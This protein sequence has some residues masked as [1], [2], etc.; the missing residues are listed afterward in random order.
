MITENEMYWL[1]RA[2]SIKDT[3]FTIYLPLFIVS[4]INL[5]ICLILQ[6]YL[7][8]FPRQGPE[9]FSVAARNFTK[10]FFIYGLTLSIVLYAGNSLIMTTAEHAAVKVI[11][12]L[13]A[14][15]KIENPELLKLTQVW[16][17]QQNAKKK[18]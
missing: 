1:V 13:T 11:P 6:A 4:C 17:E 15:Q 5:I 12:R 10:H 9:S 18:P 2:D 3:L 14:N 8:D 7:S 16:A